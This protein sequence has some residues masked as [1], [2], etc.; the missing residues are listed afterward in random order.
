MTLVGKQEQLAAKDSE[1]GDLKKEKQLLGI[2]TSKRYIQNNASFRKFE[3]CPQMAAAICK[4]RYA[5]FGS[6][7]QG[8]TMVLRSADK[9]KKSVVH[10]NHRA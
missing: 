5:E 1:I 7:L 8:S 2:E 10:S 4:D 3:L 9:V 6:L